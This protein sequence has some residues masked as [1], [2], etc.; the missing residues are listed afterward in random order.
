MVARKKNQSMGCISAVSQE[1]VNPAFKEQSN[2][3]SPQFLSQ[4][5]Q[6]HFHRPHSSS[7]RH[8]SAHFKE[9]LQP[10]IF[11]SGSLFCYYIHRVFT[12]SSSSQPPHMQD[13]LVY[14]IWC[15]IFMLVVHIHAASTTHSGNFQVHLLLLWT[16]ALHSFTSSTYLSSV[17]NTASWAG[18]QVS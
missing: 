5:Y 18:A 6:N 7:V 13:V 16:A 10:L 17:L 9:F 4:I 2:K 3:I 11:K 12:Y 14:K 8:I 1:N 15:Q